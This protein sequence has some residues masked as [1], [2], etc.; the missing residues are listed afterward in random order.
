MTTLAVAILVGVTMGLP[1]EPPPPER[2]G[3]I[4]AQ[5]RLERGQWARFDGRG[6][7]VRFRGVVYEH[8]EH[9]QATVANFTQVT[10]TGTREDSLS[11]PGQTSAPGYLIDVLGANERTTELVVHLLRPGLPFTLDRGHFVTVAGAL[12]R[13]NVVEGR[14]GH[15]TVWVEVTPPGGKEQSRSAPLPAAG[16]EPS[17][18]VLAGFRVRVYPTAG[19]RARLSIERQPAAP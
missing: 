3:T 6:L 15:R 2:A 17:T 12:I 16:A 4:G 1:A 8:D 13:A 7:R 18:L 10:R 19:P 9:H 11:V 14:P 5:L